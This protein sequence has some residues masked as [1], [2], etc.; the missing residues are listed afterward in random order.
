MA[1]R[2]TSAAPPDESQG[3]AFKFLGFRLPYYTQVPDE[4]IDVLMPKLSGAEFKIVVYICR[5]TFGFR[6]DSDDISLNQLVHGITTKE[7]RVLDQGTGLSVDTVVRALKSLEDKGVLIKTKKQSQTRGNESN[8]Y[9]LHKMAVSATP[10][11]ET[12]YSENRS[13]PQLRKSETPPTQK[14]GEGLL[15]KSETQETAL[16]N[17]ALTQETV[18]TTQPSLFA[19]HDTVV[20]ALANQGLSVNVAKKLVAEYG[21][22][23]CATKLEYFQFV[24][25]TAPTTF[26]KSPTGWLRRAIEKDF[27]PPDGF[28]S[29]AQRE[30]E[31]QRLAL[32]EQ[33]ED[34]AAERE[35]QRRQQKIRAEKEHYTKWRTELTHEYGTTDEDFAHWARVCTGLQSAYTDKTLY[36][37]LVATAEILTITPEREDE[38]GRV[39]LGVKTQYAVD[40]LNHRNKIMFER[41]FRFVLSYPVVVEFI[42]VGEPALVIEDELETDTPLLNPPLKQT[43]AVNGFSH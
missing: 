5:R 32:A 38:A 10:P 34:E 3:Q 29:R 36:E 4:V 25:D 21:S 30:E 6:K 2:T 19:D 8:N 26:R 27:A 16:Q 14:I 11:A 43:V 42:V 37:T 31:Q 1:K 24:Q 7:G 22:E 12:P 15:R 18:T 13:S 23:Y 39:L 40:R 9:A 41:E 35:M 28:I 17:T 33:A 20:V